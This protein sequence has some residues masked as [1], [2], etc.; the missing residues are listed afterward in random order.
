MRRI[1]VVTVLVVVSVLGSVAVAVAAPP[2]DGCAVGPNGPGKSTIE[3]W[4]LWAETTYAQAL[5]DSGFVDA[6]GAVELAGTV[7]EKEDRNADGWICV[8]RQVLPNDASGFDTWLVAHD[9]TAN[10]R[11]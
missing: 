7:F 3:P 10:T 11:P 6:E 4:D 9:N 1:L 2:H 5:E 8:M